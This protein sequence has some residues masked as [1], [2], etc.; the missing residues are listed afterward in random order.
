VTEW[1][2]ERSIAI[3]KRLGLSEHLHPL[4]DRRSTTVPEW[5]WLDVVEALLDRLE[6]VEGRT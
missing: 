2:N 4:I 5:V 3:R 6:A 1:T